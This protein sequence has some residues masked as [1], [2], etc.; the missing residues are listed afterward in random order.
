MPRKHTSKGRS[1]SGGRFV[2]LPHF[3]ME[4]PAWRTLPAYERAAFIEV[5]ML[6]DGGNNGFLDMG[7]RR[8]ADRLNVSVT[9]AAACLREL[10]GRGLLEVAEASAF[11]RKDRT[12]TSYRLTHVRCDRT[13][14]PGSRAYLAWRP[15]IQTTVSRGDRTV[16]RRGTVAPSQCNEV[17]L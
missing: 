1:K 13:H 14:Q 3:L 15:E 11:S 8:L 4:T 12:A 6:Y 2:A 17:I 10:I 9:K 16:S 7:V 5:A